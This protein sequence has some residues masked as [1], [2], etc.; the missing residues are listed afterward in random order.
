MSIADAAVELDAAVNADALE[1]VTLVYDGGV[2]ARALPVLPTGMDTPFIAVASGLA[3]LVFLALFF[4]TLAAPDAK[5][6]APK[7]PEGKEVPACKCETTR[8]VLS[9]Q[10]QMAEAKAVAAE[11]IAEIAKASAKESM[12][13]LLELEARVLVLSK[14]K[15]D[16]PKAAQKASKKKG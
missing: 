6:T 9:A 3:L 2:S 13:K 11:S 1:A 16:K 14:M 15:A 5:E 4:K 10:V 7:K 12:D 8:M